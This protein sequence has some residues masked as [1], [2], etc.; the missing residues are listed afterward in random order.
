M[1][2]GSPALGALCLSCAALHSPLRAASRRLG[3]RASRPLVEGERGYAWLLA[4]FLAL[5]ALLRGWPLACFRRIRLVGLGSK[6]ST[7]FQHVF[8]TFL[9]HDSSLTGTLGALDNIVTDIGVAAIR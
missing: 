2:M 1:G 3:R 5:V 8:N 4:G 7:S 9:T 6:L